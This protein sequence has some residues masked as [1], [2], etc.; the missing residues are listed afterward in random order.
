MNEYLAIDICI[1]VSLHIICSMAE[2]F[3]EMLRRFLIEHVCKERICE[4]L[5]VVQMTGYCAVILVIQ[6]NLFDIK[7]FNV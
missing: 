6:V 4:V 2:W 7:L 3:P 5:W 1:F